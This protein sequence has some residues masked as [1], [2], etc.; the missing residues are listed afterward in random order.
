MYANTGPI[1]S[2][3][4]ET[5][6]G[7]TVKVITLTSGFGIFPSGS[8]MSVFTGEGPCMRPCAPSCC[9]GACA[10]GVGIPAAKNAATAAANVPFISRRLIMAISPPSKVPR[11]DGFAGAAR[12]P[13]GGPSRSLLPTRVVILGPVRTHTHVRARSWQIAM[14]PAELG[15]GC[16]RRFVQLRLRMELRPCEPELRL[17]YQLLQTCAL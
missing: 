17:E 8:C 6:P 7:A 3:A 13:S 4:G 14:T 10:A 12:L 2:W 15:L 5:A 9:E 16:F 1:C 11:I